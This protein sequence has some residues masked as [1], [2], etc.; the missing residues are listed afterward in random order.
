VPEAERAV[1][2]S[3]D[4][5]V[6]QAAEAGGHLGGDFSTLTRVPH[7]IVAV[8][9]R[10]VVAAGGIA[11]GRSLVAALALAI[12]LRGRDASHLT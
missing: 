6:A 11:D 7:V 1:A 9:P 10:P 12:V 5:I 8:T 3:V 2:A 4:V